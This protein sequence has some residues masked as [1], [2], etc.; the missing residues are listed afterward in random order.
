MSKNFVFILVYSDVSSFI[1]I[2][3]ILIFIVEVNKGFLLFYTITESRITVALEYDFY[4]HLLIVIIIDTSY[5]N[6]LT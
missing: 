1:S 4:Y 2:E 3:L 5:F 6:H